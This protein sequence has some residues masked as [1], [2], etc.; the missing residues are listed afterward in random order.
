MV[1]LSGFHAKVVIG[2]G[3]ETSSFSLPAGCGRAQSSY[4]APFSHRRKASHRPSGEKAGDTS[5][6][7]SGPWVSGSSAPPETGKRYKR[8]A[9]AVFNRWAATSAW[10]S[11]V[12]V[13]YLRA[14]GREPERFAITRSGPPFEGITM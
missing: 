6:A 4:V 11:G 13:M 12:Q 2:T 7:P 3:L 5:C 10:L 1:R 14:A 9:K 8:S